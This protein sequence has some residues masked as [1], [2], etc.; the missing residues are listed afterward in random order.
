MITAPVL[1]SLSLLSFFTPAERP[2][3][4]AEA[5]SVVFEVA[6][7]EPEP[8]MRSVLAPLADLVALGES[9]TVGGYNAANRGR[10]MD[11]GKEGLRKVFDGRDCSEITIGEILLAQAQ[12]RLHAA[13][14]YQIIGITMPKAVRQAGLS[15]ADMFS[16]E[17]QDKLF[18]A[19]IKFKRPAVWAYLN[20]HNNHAGA[21]DAMAREWASIAY[22]DGASY[23]ASGGGDRAHVSREQILSEL[24]Q[25][26]ER[27]RTLNGAS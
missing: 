17:N 16:P 5:P 7:E 12:R 8:T 4:T 10:A 6:A 1:L 9:E 21:A 24:A 2:I 3:A 19:L 20:G 23:Y 14:R 25:T 11:L 13:G 15:G 26:R 18:L 27:M 22:W